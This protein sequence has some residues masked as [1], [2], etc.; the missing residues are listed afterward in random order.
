M[1][2][3]DTRFTSGN[4]CWQLSIPSPVTYEKGLLQVTSGKYLNGFLKNLTPV[5]DALGIKCL[6]QCFH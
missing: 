4:D 5:K 6:L 1:I 3:P 2:G